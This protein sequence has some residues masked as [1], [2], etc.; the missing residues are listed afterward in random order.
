MSSDNR[1]YS[2]YTVLFVDDEVNILNSLRRGLIDEDYEM[3]FATRGQEA[4]DILSKRNIS[5]IISD[6]KMPGMDGLT[7]LKEVRR[8]YPKTVRIVLSGYTQLQQ[9]LV[10]VNQADIFRFITKPW[11]MEEEF[12][13][14]IRQAIDYHILQIERDDFEKAL[15]QK[16]NAYQN[17]L[18]RI[19]DIIET[20]KKDKEII[21]AAGNE[22]IANATAA[23]VEGMGYVEIKNKLLAGLDVFNEVSLAGFGDKK[24]HMISE[25]MEFMRAFIKEQT[26]IS[27]SEVDSDLNEFTAFS[28]GVELIESIFKIS[29]TTF[30]HDIEKNVVKVMV[31][32]EAAGEGLF[33][34]SVL[35]M[36]KSGSNTAGLKDIRDKNTDSLIDLYNKVFDRIMKISGGSYS[37]ARVEINVVLKIVIGE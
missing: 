14:T 1:N 17:I 32:K 21:V 5:V 30:I 12:T 23:A 15:M 13:D 22:I 29:L 18:K 33:S 20:A 9:V 3:V 4:L 25:V 11:K 16:N 27:A 28:T 8:L 24:K 6:M 31:R 19:E 10:T 2:D 34:I 37:C 35:I 26:N 7:L 36:N